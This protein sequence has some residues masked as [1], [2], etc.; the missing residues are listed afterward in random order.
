LDLVPDD[1]AVVVAAA[2]EVRPGL[3]DHW[4]DVTTSL[5]SDDADHLY[6]PPEEVE[7]ALD[8]RAAVSFS[9]VSQDQPHQLRAQAADGAARSIREAEP[10]LEKLVRGGYSTVVAWERQ[11][12]AERAA[13]N[14]A[15][16][17]PSFVD[18]TGPSLRTDDGSL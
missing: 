14:M 15:R 16:L 7:A 8:D 1:A 12:E 4:H 2:D 9:T 10:E 5:H 17:R 13:Y 3:A 18:G 6:L 11:G